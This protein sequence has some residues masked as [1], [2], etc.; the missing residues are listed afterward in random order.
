MIPLLFALMTVHVGP[1][2]KSVSARQP[3]MAAEGALVALAYGE[4]NAIY[5]SASTDRGAHFSA[6]VKVAEPAA[7]MLGRHRGPRIAI[8]G[9]A[10]VITAIAGE[11]MSETDLYAWRS[12]D[13]GAH[14]STGKIV[15]DVPKSAREGLDA[16]SSDGKGKL[17]VAWLDDRG[18]RKQLWGARSVDAGAT[19]SKN[20]LM[21]ESPD[22]HICECCHPS[23]SMDGAGHVL[24]MWRNWLGGSRDMYLARSED[25][26]TFSKA[27]K[28]G[29]GTWQIDACPMD[30]GGLSV[31]GSRIVSA[32]RRGESI[33]AASPGQAE[34]KLGD[35]KDVALAL[36]GERMH[37]VW[38]SGTKIESWGDGKIETLSDAGAFPAIVRLPGGGVLVAWEEAGTIAVRGLQR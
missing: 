28:L 11:K 26:V 19:W 38:T 36:D 21:Y 13:G 12:T 17:F 3:Q 37:A 31:S 33:F 14:W 5:F 32:W 22:G 35:G 27:E 16:L 18:T 9:Q 34:V 2:V 4:G 23:V 29:T 20:V 7:L 6:P 25:G 10:L 8:A 15:N 24:A 30:G 1:V